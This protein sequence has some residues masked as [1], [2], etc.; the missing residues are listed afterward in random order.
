M[1]TTREFFDTHVIANEYAVFASDLVL[2][3][4]GKTRDSAQRERLLDII[5]R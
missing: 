1:R 4:I 2:R 3:E 5:R